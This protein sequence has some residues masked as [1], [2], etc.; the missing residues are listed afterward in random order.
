MQIL[1]CR[2]LSVGSG[3][4]RTTTRSEDSGAGP[5][6]CRAST[7]TPFDCNP[8]GNGSSSPRTSCGTSA[9]SKADIHWSTFTVCTCVYVSRLVLLCER[10]HLHLAGDIY[11][12]NA[13]GEENLGARRWLFSCCVWY[14]DH[15][16]PWTLMSKLF[17]WL[18]PFICRISPA[19][20]PP[21]DT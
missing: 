1:S 5:P 17:F 8:V 19:C 3:T 11:H 9:P 10:I 6:A 16:V 12:L 14:D 4:G 13:R 20:I 2:T 18:S 15:T 21:I 7:V